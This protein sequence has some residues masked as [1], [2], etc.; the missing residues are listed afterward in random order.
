M[1]EELGRLINTLIEGSTCYLCG[2][3]LEITAEHLERESDDHFKTDYQCPGCD[4]CYDIEVIDR[5]T[6]ISL[7]AFRVDIEKNTDLA[8]IFRQTRKEALQR[9]SHPAKDLVE[10]SIELANALTI[11]QVNKG[12]L[13]EAANAFREEGFDVGADLR[14]RTKADLHNYMASAYS[15]EQIVENIEPQLPL[16]TNIEAAKE[17]FKEEHQ[18]IKGLRTYAQHHL[19]LPFSLAHFYDENTGAYEDTITV[20]MDDVVDFDYNDPDISYEKV[21]GDSINIERRV[22]LHYNAASELVN[23]IFEY[24]Q[25]EYRAELEDYR[26][27]TTYEFPE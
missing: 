5:E 13:V 20:S 16:G 18:I 19:T 8:E 27:A 24:L 1:D 26:E 7:K 9:E 12:R 11:L 4:V 22:K 25:S 6:M 15:F 23:Q 21:E 10:G 14:R 2:T 3:P 17:E